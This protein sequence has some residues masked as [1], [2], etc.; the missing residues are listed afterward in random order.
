VGI[1]EVLFV[2]TSKLG[3]PASDSM[4]ARTCV[5]AC[6]LLPDAPAGRDAGGW[7]GFIH[8]PLMTGQVGDKRPSLSLDQ[9]TGYPDCACNHHGGIA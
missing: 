5:C 7:G 1:L 8:V 3:I 4:S 9:G 6:V 2:E